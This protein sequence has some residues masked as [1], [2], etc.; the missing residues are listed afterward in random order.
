MSILM[1]WFP[2]LPQ[3]QSSIISALPASQNLSKDLMKEW[4]QGTSLVWSLGGPVVKNPPSYTGA[5]GSIPG[6]GRFHRWLLFSHSV[7]S[8]SLR[9]QGLQHSRLPCPSSPRACSNS[10][11]L[12]WWCHPV[13]LL[14]SIFPS[15]KVFSN[16]SSSHQVAE[17][18]EL[19]HQS[20][21][22]IF[23]TDFLYMWRSN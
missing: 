4:I 7:M 2:H 3:K 14:P 12:S 22:W 13:L 23:R 8:S 19:Q 9:P 5:T 21:P 15:I 6:L 18:V 17:V 1:P 11:P 16:V 20:F 10:C